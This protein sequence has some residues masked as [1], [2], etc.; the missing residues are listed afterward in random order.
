MMTNI[1]GCPQTPEALVRQLNVALQAV[2][3]DAAFGDHADANGFVPD[4]RDGAGWTAEAQDERD[5]LA[6]L[7]ATEP[8][9]QDGTG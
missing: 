3:D 5:E 6:K 2:V 9:L 1:V 8:W 7:W 4:W